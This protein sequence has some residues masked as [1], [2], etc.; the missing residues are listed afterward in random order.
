M[1]DPPKG[2]QR[3]ERLGRS[4]EALQELVA[5]H[6]EAGRWNGDGEVLLPGH[7]LDERAV[8][9]D[10]ELVAGPASDLDHRA[11]HVRATREDERPNRFRPVR[12]RCAV[13][14]MLQPRAAKIL[15]RHPF[16]EDAVEPP[17]DVEQLLFDTPPRGGVDRSTVVLVLQVA[18]V[19]N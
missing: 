17:A 5:V 6:P 14:E 9:P 10:L 12:L 11:G 16:R 13:V 3:V 19:A 18:V 2:S 7:A 1:L 4:A 15:L 8:D